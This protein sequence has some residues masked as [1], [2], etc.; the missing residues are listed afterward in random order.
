[1]FEV[2]KLY[3]YTANLWYFFLNALHPKNGALF[4]DVC[5]VLITVVSISLETNIAAQIEA[6]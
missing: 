4:G 3:I 2:D 1:M 5:P 6:P